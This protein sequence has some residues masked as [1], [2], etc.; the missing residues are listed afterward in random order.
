[1]GVCRCP[2]VRWCGGAW[3]VW[4]T[5]ECSARAR[6]RS[7]RSRACSRAWVGRW[8]EDGCTDGWVVR[9][10]CVCVRAR[11]CVCVCMERV[12]ACVYVRVVGGGWVGGWWVGDWRWVG[13]GWW[14]GSSVCVGGRAGGRARVGACVGGWLRACGAVPKAQEGGNGGAWE[15]PDT[16]RKIGCGWSVSSDGSNG[17]QGVSGHRLLGKSSAWAL[18]GSLMASPWTARGVPAHR[19]RSSAWNRSGTGGE[20]GRSPLGRGHGLVGCRRGPL[21]LA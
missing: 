15:V 11:V 2:C 3:R 6:T 10:A 16:H 18:S 1:M 20:L 14:V 13:G 19:A 9:W 21:R 17:P 4:I 12:R 7:A 8:V 5:I